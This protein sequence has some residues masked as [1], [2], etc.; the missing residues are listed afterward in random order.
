MQRAR[1]DLVE[2]KVKENS[3]LDGVQLSDFYR[4]F[5]V[6]ILVCAAAEARRFSYPRAIS[7]YAAA[8]SLPYSL[9]LPR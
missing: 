7:S 6:K 9:P 3:P 8:I 4:Q 1:I 2:F 5:K